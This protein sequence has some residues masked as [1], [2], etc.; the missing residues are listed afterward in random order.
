[1]YKALFNVQSFHNSEKKVIHRIC[2]NQGFIHV[3]CLLLNRD[4]LLHSKSKGCHGMG[5]VHGGNKRLGLDGS[6]LV[7]GMVRSATSTTHIPSVQYTVV[8]RRKKLKLLKG[9]ILNYS[10]RHKCP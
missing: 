4:K 7:L 1:M 3:F 6:V 9:L 5:L 2:K 8:H 10:F